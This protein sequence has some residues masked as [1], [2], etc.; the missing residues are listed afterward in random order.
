MS[1]DNIKK[2]YDSGYTLDYIPDYSNVIGKT[3]SGKVDRPLGSQHPKH[4]DM[5]YPVNYGYVE[6]V[7]AA[8]GAEQDVYILGI[9]EPE[10]KVIKVFHRFNDTEDKWIVSVNGA[11]IPEDKILGDIAFQEQ[12]F[13]GELSI[14]SL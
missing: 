14:C 4:P 12:F 13:Y 2:L 8:D 9:D 6:G 10:G 3:V 11:D 5:I 1:V 7:M